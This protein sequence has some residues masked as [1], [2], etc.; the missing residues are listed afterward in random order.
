VGKKGGGK[1][2]CVEKSNRGTFPLRL[3][4]PQQ[5]RDFALFPPPDYGG[6]TGSIS[7][8]NKNS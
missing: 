1:S 2:R 7:R 4:I 5:Q 3:E 8:S 6:F